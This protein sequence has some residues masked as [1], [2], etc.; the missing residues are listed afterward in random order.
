VGRDTAHPLSQIEF[1][2]KEDVPHRLAVPSHMAVQSADFLRIKLL[3]R[4][5]VLPSLRFVGRVMLQLRQ[6]YSCA[7]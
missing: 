4:G 1:C 2:R 5:A 3:Q 7:D 6:K